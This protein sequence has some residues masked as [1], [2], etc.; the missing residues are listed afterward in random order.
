[1]GTGESITGWVVIVIMIMTFI[2]WISVI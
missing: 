2:T 1:L